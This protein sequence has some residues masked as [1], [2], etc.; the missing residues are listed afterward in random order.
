[1]MYMC[2]CVYV[3]CMCAYLSMYVYVWCECAYTCMMCVR[4][5][6]SVYVWYVCTYVCMYGWMDG[7]MVCEYVCVCVWCVCMCMDGV[8]M[9]MCVMYVSTHFACRRVCVW[10]HVCGHIHVCGHDGLWGIMSRIILH[11][12]STSLI[13]A[14]LLNQTQSSAVCLVLL[15]GHHPRLDSW[16]SAMLALR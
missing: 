6:V 2:V 16:W 3:W 11:G 4:V 14:W 12:S 1:M 15:C 7:W 9:C 5:C 8:H 13:K 10:A